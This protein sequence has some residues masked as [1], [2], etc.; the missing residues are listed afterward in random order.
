MVYW[1]NAATT[2]P[3]PQAVQMAVQDSMIKFGA[4][5]GRGGHRM[6]INAAQQVYDCREAVAAF[7]GLE[8]PSGVIFTSNCTAALNM[9][10]HGVL[11]SGGRALISDLEHNAVWRP[12][13]ALSVQRPRF[14]IAAWSADEDELVENFRRAI[15]PDTKLVVCTHASNVFGVT[16]PLGRLAQLA[17][18]HGILFCV[19][20][21]QTAGVLPIDMQADDIDYL[22]V[23][24]HKGLYAPMGMGMLL[25][26]ER[27]RVPA[28]IQGG[29]GSQSTRTNQPQ[30]LPERL[31]SGTTNMLGISGLMAGLRF[32]EQRG[33]D[34]IY[35][36]EV[37]LLSY[38]YERL[39]N[40]QGV[41]LYTKK[42]QIGYS[43]PVMSV[44]IKGL[45]SEQ[46]AHILDQN[47]VAVRAGL[48][49]APLAHRH[50][51][52]LP[53]GTVRLAPSV[54]SDHAQADKICKLFN[55]IVQKT[56]HS[57]KYML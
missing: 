26:R 6:S 47:G 1:D 14:D 7:F 30:E 39:S 21:A 13:N 40:M 38:V 53:D 10:I 52:T 44:N 50:F 37:G 57:R 15:R 11:D 4:N 56:L 31:E 2:W 32:V 25:C 49:C 54:Y 48:H 33:R 35:A 27:S 17:H 5:P 16:F 18:Q 3:K 12:V 8:D 29:T 22:C 45:P 34:V 41:E 42:P 28:R 36:H 51:G 19:D 55:Q 20:A 9:V 43:A 23:A 24:A 46:L